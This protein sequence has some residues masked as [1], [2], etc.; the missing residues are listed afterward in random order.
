VLG[1]Y[2]AS[3]FKEGKSISMP[4]GGNSS[5]VVGVRSILVNP[6]PKVDSNQ[7]SATS[8]GDS[9]MATIDSTLPYLWLP[10][11]V[12]DS[13]AALFRLTYDNTTKLYTVNQTAHDQNKVMNAT[14][15]FQLVNSVSSN[16]VVSIALP[17]SAFDLQ[18]TW[19]IYS[20]PVNYFPIRK[21][22]NGNFVLGRAFLQEA[23]LI[24]DYER[25]NFTVAQAA[26]SDPM[27]S[28]TIVP[29]LA[30]K[31]STNGGASPTPTLITPPAGS[32]SKGLGGG[33]IAGIAIG[34]VAVLL[35]IATLIYYFRRQN[36]EKE[37]VRKIEQPVLRIGDDVDVTQMTQ[38]G[39]PSI[40]KIRR[41]SELES[42]TPG[43]NSSRTSTQGYF[44]PNGEWIESHSPEVQQ[45]DIMA[46][47][48]Y[49]DPIAERMRSPSDPMV[50]PNSTNVYE[51]PASHGFSEVES[52]AATPSPPLSSSPQMQQAALTHRPPIKRRKRSQGGS[53]DSNGVKTDSNRVETIA[54][55]D[56]L[57][58]SSSARPMSR[59][60]EALDDSVAVEKRLVGG[61]GSDL[62]T[63]VVPT[64]TTPQPHHGHQ[65]SVGSRM[66]AD[67][68]AGLEGGEPGPE[69]M[70]SGDPDAITPVHGHGNAGMRRADS[71]A[72]VSSDDTMVDEGTK[73]MR[74]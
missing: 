19:P 60:Q 54:E 30:P 2:D 22:P 48:D 20:N 57:Y 47:Q 74:P 39:R 25:N 6:D 46:K 66:T 70:P 27:P 55:E 32:G 73:D 9:F 68:A 41:I 37:R 65:S 51:L 10:D 28:P 14:I 21:S 8:S 61:M 29:I 24:V 7:Y 40:S 16:D 64:S 56:T 23:Y 18:A 62:S 11:S 52:V 69:V 38:N 34:A 17:Y 63:P 53:G 71:N 49:F 58:S 26:F 43:Y 36:I 44:G 3:L 31:D 42:P 33:A 1:G 59:F 13:M 5:L 45:V 35:L 12:C 15:T 4:G 50:S 67:E 72:S